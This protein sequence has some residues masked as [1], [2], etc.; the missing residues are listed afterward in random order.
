MVDCPL[1][2]ALAQLGAGG[3]GIVQHD[4]VQLLFALVGVDGGQQH[5]AGFFT[6]H[7]SGG[8][9]DDGAEGLA[10]QLLGLVELGARPTASLLSRI[11]RESSLSDT[12]PALLP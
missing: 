8:Q 5:T 6:H 4:Q 1:S 10:D 3:D 2:I 9:V 7:L 11:F 12:L